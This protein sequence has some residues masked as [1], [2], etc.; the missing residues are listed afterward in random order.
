[1]S[2]NTETRQLLTSVDVRELNTLRWGPLRAMFPKFV[3]EIE[4]ARYLRRLL[5]NSECRTVQIEP[6]CEPDGRRST[7]VFDV[8]TV[9]QTQPQTPPV[10]AVWLSDIG[11]GGGSE[12]G[13]KV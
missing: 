12:P 11:A 6:H 10:A 9:D 1:M 4:L 5:A 13:G 8:F 3:E 7:H 2:T